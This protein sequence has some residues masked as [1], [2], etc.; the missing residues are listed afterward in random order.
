MVKER[1]FACPNCNA[2]ITYS[3]M[4]QDCRNGGNGMCSCEYMELKWDNKYNKFEPV[5]MR[6]FYEY[7]EITKK[8]YTELNEMSTMDRI[9]HAYIPVSQMIKQKEI[10]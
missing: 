4:I 1:Y 10:K 9:L 5:C 8:L 6:T 3:E 7:V 2:P